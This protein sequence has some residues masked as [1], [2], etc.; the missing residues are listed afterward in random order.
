M[1]YSNGVVSQYWII[2][3]KTFS[4]ERLLDYFVKS[5]KSGFFHKEVFDHLHLSYEQPLISLNQELNVFKYILE[6]IPE[7]RNSIMLELLSL[8]HNCL[9]PFTFE[10]N[11]VEDYKDFVFQLLKSSS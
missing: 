5:L 1:K 4:N 2:F 6:S 3:F 7:Q 8:S 11:K 9:N 10:E